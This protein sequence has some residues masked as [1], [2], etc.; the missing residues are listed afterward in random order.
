MKTL[1]CGYSTSLGFILALL[2]VAS[3]EADTILVT[4]ID[5]TALIQVERGDF[6]AVAYKALRLG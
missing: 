1:H 4:S 3:A 5:G 2:V 6:L